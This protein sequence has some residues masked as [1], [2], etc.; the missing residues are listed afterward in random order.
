MTAVDGRLTLKVASA[1]NFPGPTRLHLEPKA[2][3][4]LAWVAQWCRSCSLRFS[5]DGTRG[6]GSGRHWRTLAGTGGP[7]SLYTRSQ[8]LARPH[9]GGRSRRHPEEGGVSP[10]ETTWKAAAEPVSGPAYRI[11]DLESFLARVFNCTFEKSKREARTNPFK[12][13]AFCPEWSFSGGRW[14]QRFSGLKSIKWQGENQR[15]L[16]QISQEKCRFFSCFPIHPPNRPPIHQSIRP[17]TQA[18]H[19]FPMITFRAHNRCDLESICLKPKKKLHLLQ[20]T[21]ANWQQQQHPVI[22]V[23][24]A[25]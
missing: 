24:Y 16:K 4:E 9:A 2:E 6:C 1:A 15:V 3:R 19:P 14:R 11:R 20:P 12:R 5:S 21:R 13:F 10:E 25:V 22:T 8:S 7:G 17:S 23:T 18:V